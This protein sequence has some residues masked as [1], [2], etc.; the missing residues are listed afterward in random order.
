MATRTL[1]RIFVLALAMIFVLPLVMAAISPEILDVGKSYQ[2]LRK[3]KG[4][5]DGG[6]YNDDVD[7]FNGA[8]HLA[9][10]KLADYFKS[11][12]QVSDVI[13]AMGKPDEERQQLVEA[14]QPSGQSF[15]YYVYKWRGNH[16]FLWF[17]VD[18]AKGKVTKSAWYYAYE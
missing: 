1:Y 14:A 18:A 12:S 6:D 5:W 8:K 7:S 16:D 9:M 13:S 15:R 11:G 17:R 4:H 2:V 3:T 10:Q